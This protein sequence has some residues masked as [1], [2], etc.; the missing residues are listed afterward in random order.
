MHRA[1]FV[2]YTDVDQPRRNPFQ[3]VMIGLHIL[4]EIFNGS[5]NG[6]EAKREEKSLWL[7]RFLLCH[8]TQG[9]MMA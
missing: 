8:G 1:C 9:K 7:N 5:R 6:P 3:H 4:T 2:S